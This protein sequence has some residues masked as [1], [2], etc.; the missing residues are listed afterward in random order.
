MSEHERMEQ[1]FEANA[2]KAFPE[3]FKCFFN[4]SKTE[5]GEYKRAAAQMFWAAWQAAQYGSVK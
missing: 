1:F 3:Y 4:W 2:G 5:D